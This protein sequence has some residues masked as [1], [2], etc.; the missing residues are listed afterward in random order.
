MTRLY[1]TEI[2]KNNITYLYDDRFKQEKI[3]MIKGKLSDLK[4]WYYKS[5][6]LCDLINCINF[7]DLSKEDIKELCIV[8]YSGGYAVGTI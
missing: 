1:L 4:E 8:K 5:S 2:R 6:G 3:K 7:N